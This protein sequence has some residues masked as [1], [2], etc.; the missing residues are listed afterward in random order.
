M[1]LR[2]SNSGG[3]FW[4]GP[5]LLGALLIGVGVLIILL[6][7]LLAYAVAA[8][9]IVVGVGLVGASVSWRGS[10]TYRRLDGRFPEDAD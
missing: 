5:A 2:F 10:V 4:I 9:F 7:Q 1:I 3:M 8:L 6:P